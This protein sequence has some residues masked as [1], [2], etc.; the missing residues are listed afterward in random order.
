[1]ANQITTINQPETRQQLQ[2]LDLKPAGQ[3]TT[4]SQLS[5]CLALVRPVSMSDDAAGEWLTVAASDLAH[6]PAD[7]L[8]DACKAARRECTYH[9]QIVPFVVKDA[10]ERMRHRRVIVGEPRIPVERRIERERW[11]PEAGELEAIKNEV[12]R[13][14]GR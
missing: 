2:S 5:A 10:D 12:A 6:Y 8:A 4:V 7:I 3:R 14:F 1:M 11:V 13:E 9:G